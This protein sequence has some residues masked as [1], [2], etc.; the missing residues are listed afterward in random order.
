[1]F[2]QKDVSVFLQQLKFT[3]DGDDVLA[4]GTFYITP[5]STNVAQ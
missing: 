3:A 5:V 1:M 4:R 2:K